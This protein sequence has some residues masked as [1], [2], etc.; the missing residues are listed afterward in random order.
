MDFDVLAHGIVAGSLYAL[1]AVSFNILF[2]PTNVFN[3]AQGELVMLGAMIFASLT[4]LA[5]APWVVAFTATLVA[6]G[7]IGLIEERGRPHS[8]PVADG[9]GLGH[10][11]PG[12][13]TDHLQSGRALLGA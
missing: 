9:D 13:V 5:G 4:S 8:R 3:F 2:R 6:V 10:H 11:D 1:V 7:C 12:D